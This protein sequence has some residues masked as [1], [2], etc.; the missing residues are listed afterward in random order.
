M[1]GVSAPSPEEKKDK[2]SRVEIF[3]CST[4]SAIVRFP[5]YGSL[6]KLLLTRKGR[7]G[8]FANVCTRDSTF[9]FIFFS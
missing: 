7:C 8:E 5:R 4:C 6:K 2:A 1:Q 9:L 3:K